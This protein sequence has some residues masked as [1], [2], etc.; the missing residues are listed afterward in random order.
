MR[1]ISTLLFILSACLL[2]IVSYALLVA[3]PRFSAYVLVG[4]DAGYYF[5]IARN[6]LLGHGLSFDR[7]HET[8]GFNPLLTALLIGAFRL[9]V[10]DLSVIGCYRVGIMVTL[11]ANLGSLFLLVRLVG[12]LLDEQVFTG[13]LRRLAIATATLFFAGFIALK[14]NY[15]MD[16]PLVFLI[17]L[18][19][20]DRVR[21][22]GLVS[23]GAGAALVD[24]AL[25]ALLFLAR[26]DSLPFL[27]AAFALMAVLALRDRSLW[28][29][30]VARGIMSVAI[31]AP[32]LLWSASH[33]GAWLPVSARLKSRFPVLDL[34]ASMDVVLHSSLNPA[35]LGSFALAFV[36]ALATAI[37]FFSALRRRPAAELLADNRLA[38]LAVL[39]A[40]LLMRLTYMAMFSRLDVQGS[41]VIL[42]HAFNLLMASWVAGGLAKRA[43]A[44]G[45]AER[46]RIGQLVCALLMLV[47]LVLVVGKSRAIQRTWGNTESGGSGDEMALGQAI[48]A[49]TTASDV[50]YGG[51]YGLVGFFADRAWINGDGVANTPQYQRVLENGELE[52]YLAE[53]RVTHLVFLRPTGAPMS[54]GQRLKVRSELN[55]RVNYYSV[56]DSASVL[57]WYSLRNGGCT[58]SLARYSAPAQ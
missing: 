43:G 28:V 21:Q 57:D 3:D 53:N 8:N 38:V 26:V 37:W 4:D 42:A 58:V 56:A 45:T 12:G 32:Y 18:A 44:A 9:F 48:H 39:A 15:G 55:G 51:A 10:H 47:T 22:H 20:L 29:P 25:L 1:S 52:A 40:Y 5:A 33:F 24:G 49:N 16:A 17:G 11:L 30:I 27:V 54:Q 6:F 34:P 35:D 46:A 23:R 36:V 13:A 31:A 50:I 19:Y 2:G 41:Y 7:L 14:S